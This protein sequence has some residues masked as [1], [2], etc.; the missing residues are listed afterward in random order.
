MV[1]WFQA[2]ALVVAFHGRT[3]DDATARRY[4]RARPKGS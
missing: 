3:S 4:R 2:H 1:E